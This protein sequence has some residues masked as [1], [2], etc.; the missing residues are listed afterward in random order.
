VSNAGELLRTPLAAT[1]EALGA[2]MTPFA[3]WLMPIQYAGIVAE[4]T[5]TREAAGLFDLSHMGRLTVTGPDAVQLLQYTTTNDVT[6]LEEGAIQYSLICN[7]RGGVVEDLLV[8][9]YSDAWRLVVNASNRVRVLEIFDDI[10]EQQRFHATEHDDTFELALLAVQGPQSEAV[11]Q[12]LVEGDLG[13]LAYYHAR[14]DRLTTLLIPSPPSDVI[15][16]PGPAGAEPYDPGGG[17][18][19]GGD[20]T[21]IL[22]SR[23]GYTGEDGFEVIIAAAA[24][25]ALWG[26]LL[27]DARVRPVGLGARDTLRLEAGM[28]LYGH[29]LTEDV[30]PFEAR[31]GRVVRLDKGRFLG[32]NALAGLH[33]RPPARRLVG[34]R[35]SAGAVPRAGHPVRRGG[36]HVGEIA[37]GTF[38]PTL[39]LPIATGYVR[40]DCAEEGI[41]VRVPVRDT[42]APAHVVPLPFVPHHTKRAKS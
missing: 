17:H 16:P 1:H 2:R 18:D 3:G 8:Y 19:V 9:R 26:M 40:S 39:R 20:R 15:A 14:S 24:A 7:E 35:F 22:L 13:T 25:P 41:E 28:A 27:S 21:P 33:G 42:E 30:T 36:E 23:T 32:S 29:E 38:S 34:L 4:H 5:H 12:P 10:V 37:S 31:L 6:R 11:L